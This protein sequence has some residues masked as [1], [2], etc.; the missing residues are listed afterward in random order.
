MHFQSSR[1][2]RFYSGLPFRS[3]SR[4]SFWGDIG[5]AGRSGGGAAAAGSLSALERG[6]SMAKI[7]THG[8]AMVPIGVS[9]AGGT[10]LLE[11]DGTAAPS[12]R[13]PHTAGPQPLPAS[14]RGDGSCEVMQSR[15]ML[16]SSEETEC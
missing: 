10:R 14:V 4:G 3:H 2:V 8:F 9:I 1:P 13:Q 5:D 7:P 6:V 16:P 12:L 11:S 15:G